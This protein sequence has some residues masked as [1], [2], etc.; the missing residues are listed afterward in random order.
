MARRARPNPAWSN[1][2]LARNWELIA[3]RVGPR[4]MPRLSDEHLEHLA[5]V[6][7]GH[8][9]YGVVAPTHDPRVVF[10]LTSDQSE[11]H[12]V[13]AMKSAHLAPAG[14]VR[15]G[16][17][18]ALENAHDGR[19]LFAL[20]R[21][22]A[23]DV[24]EVFAGS[25][26]DDEARAILDAMFDATA[27]TCKV[28]CDPD[29]PRAS[30]ERVTRVAREYAGRTGYEGGGSPGVLTR[31]GRAFSG[32]ETKAGRGLAIAGELVGDLA[33][34]PKYRLVARALHDL[35]RHGLLVTDVHAGNFGRVARGVVVTDPGNVAFL[36]TRYDRAWPPS[37]GR[38]SESA[39]A[40]CDVR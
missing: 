16:R 19:P 1:C 23:K 26:E 24:G 18:F 32:G 6:E 10:K 15:Y 7:Y 9:A 4:L 14:V 20:W 33:K 2:S 35:M 25:P 13:A 27:A 34:L 3:R 11:A 17:I 29:A 8:G 37:L 5:M 30:L 40:R 38:P 39:S 22:E 21:E 12:F 36:S 28:A 31:V